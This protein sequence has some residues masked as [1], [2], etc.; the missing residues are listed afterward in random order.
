MIIEFDGDFPVARGQH[1]A[2]V[3]VP[4]AL[5]AVVAA[6][7]TRVRLVN[8]AMVD[9][10]Q[11]AAF[12]IDDLGRKHAAKV[13]GLPLVQCRFEDE[14]T[15][16]TDGQW[17]I[18]TAGEA[19]EEEERRRWAHVRARRDQ[20]LAACDWTQ[21]PD[22]RLTSVQRKEWQDYRQALRDVPRAFSDPADVN[23]PP[24]PGERHG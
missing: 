8:G 14:L 22:A 7:W 2:G 5:K 3:P 6:D 23:F 20:L 17:R 9:A 19:A 11:F 13:R 1:T 15:R 21:L 24:K 16:D 12:Y 10:S 4:P 18:K